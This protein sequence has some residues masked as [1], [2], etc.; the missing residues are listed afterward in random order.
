MS[1]DPRALLD[2]VSRLDE[3]IDELRDGGQA[4]SAQLVAMARLEL[5]R[6]A[7]HISEHEMG[8][9]RS[10]VEDKAQIPS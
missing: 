1:S 7:H 4:L 10:L 9:L 8:V 2:I 5:M 3:V 6:T